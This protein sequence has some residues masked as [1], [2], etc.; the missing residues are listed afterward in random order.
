M[1]F[2]YKVYFTERVKNRVVCWDPDA[3]KA[4]VIAGRDKTIA[5]L[6]MSQPYGLGFDG[7]GHLL[8]ADKFNH[9]ILVRTSRID[10]VHPCWGPESFRGRKPDPALARIGFPRSPTSVQGMRDGGW[11]VAYSDDGSIY[12]YMPSGRLELIIGVPEAIP[13]AHSGLKNAIAPG[14]AE[15]EPLFKP[16]AAVIGP[17]GTVV[18]IERGFQ[19]V[20]EYHPA[21]G[22]TLLG[23]P[24][25]GARVDV[26]ALPMDLALCDL[27][28]S[29]PTGLAFDKS[30]GLY[31]SDAIHRRVW[32]IDVRAGRARTVYRSGGDASA[33]RGGPSAIGLGED[34]TL[35]ILDYAIGQVVGVRVSVNEAVQIAA[36]CSTIYESVMCS[37]AEGAGIACGP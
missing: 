16:T 32:L 17:D 12:R 37:A 35:W 20:R 33:E 4:D 3:G 7:Q 25:S 27:T 15:L 6:A 8:I 21:R 34:G 5:G 29:H 24:G 26:T 11:L 23:K 9:R 30:G 2:G 13:S 18:F 1:P 14:L 36:K 10:A 28:F 22:L 19:A 31:V